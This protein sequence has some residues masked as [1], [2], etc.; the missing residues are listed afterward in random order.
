MSIPVDTLM[1]EAKCYLCL[2]ISI[3]SALQLALLNRI[4][5]TSVKVYRA[6]LTQTGLNAPTAV[7]LENTIGN[8]V[9]N[10][11]APGEYY[12]ELA[13][14]FPANKTFVSF[15][16]ADGDAPSAVGIVRQTDSQVWVRVDGGDG[17]L[18]VYGQGNSVEILV[19]P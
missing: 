14:A 15:S 3:E 9:W 13:N 12:G 1:E 10:Y 5:G 4:S 16:A 6:L 2:G 18:G 11:D 8:I 17:V 19:Y 7:V